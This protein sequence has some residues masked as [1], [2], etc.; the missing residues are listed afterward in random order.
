[1]KLLKTALICFILSQYVLFA[2][3]L[4]EKVVCQLSFFEKDVY[5]EE[6]DIKLKIEIYN[7]NPFAVSLKIAE[8]K[9]HNL[10]FFAQTAHGIKVN[11]SP[12]YSTN[13]ESR[14]LVLLKDMSIEPGEVFGFIVDLKDY[15]NLESPGL[16]YLRSEFYP[17]TVHETN[18]GISSNILKLSIRPGHKTV[19]DT[20]VYNDFVFDDQAAEVMAD[21]K[22]SPDIIIQNILKARQTD[23]W[24]AF[25]IYL[26]LE[27]LLSQSEDLK[28]RYTRSGEN[29]R[30]YMLE[31]FKSNISSG[32]LHSEFIKKPGSYEILKTSYTKD[33]ATVKVLEKFY[34]DEYTD[35]KKYTYYLRKAEG[36]WLVYNYS[37]ENYG[38]E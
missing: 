17:S 33:E 25:F 6:S 29:E 28:N 18:V 36:F 1:M 15:L 37:V 9:L 24:S 32:K 23:R 30:Y 16:Y 11:S 2:N 20:S 26:D 10:A 3:T 4:E 7:N 14:K 35:L 31:D 13:R 12:S 21:K 38:K 22:D 27:S 19:T 8:N 5:Y 34:Y